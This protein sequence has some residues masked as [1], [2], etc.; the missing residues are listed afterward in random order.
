MRKNKKLHFNIV[1]VGS[2]NLI[3][4]KKLTKYIW[5]DDKKYKV[6]QVISPTKYDD[7]ILVS[8]VIDEETHEDGESPIH[9]MLLDAHNHEFYTDIP[10]VRKEMALR[11]Q[12]KTVLNSRNDLL[13]DNWLGIFKTL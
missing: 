7:Y 4:K 8:C 10:I 11:K 1:A 5:C 3:N 9:M 13:V 2:C 6:E 12:A